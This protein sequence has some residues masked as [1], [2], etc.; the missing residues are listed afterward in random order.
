MVDDTGSR[1]E[2]GPFDC[3][4]S[5]CPAWRPYDADRLSALDVPE[6]AATALSVRGLPDGAFEHFVRVPERELDVADL[7]ECGKAAFLGQVWDGFNNTYWLDLGDG[8]VWMRYGGAEEPA[9]HT[10]RINTSVEALQS[11]LSVYEAYVRAE[12][13]HLDTTA[14]EDLINQ[15]VIHAVAADPEAFADDENW[16]PQTFLEIEFTSARILRGDRSL[17]QLVTRD[18]VGRWG[19]DHP[20]YEPDDLG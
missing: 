6:Q 4:V 11:V 12:S 18:D 16:W 14:R 15:S 17:F 9:H 8:S 3:R 19:L 2:A 7:P 5:T 10:K 1:I 13:A 20:G